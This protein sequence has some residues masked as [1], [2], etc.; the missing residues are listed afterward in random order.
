[1]ALLFFYD[2]YLTDKGKNNRTK[3]L[4][5]TKLLIFTMSAC[6]HLK[7]KISHKVRKINVILLN[8]NIC[9][10]LLSLYL[11]CDPSDSPLDPFQSIY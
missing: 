1:M 6:Q 4:L 9:S 7:M 3:V 2:P 11:Y 10:C 5:G 8:R